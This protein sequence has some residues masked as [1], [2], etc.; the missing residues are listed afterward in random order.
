MTPPNVIQHLHHLRDLG[1]ATRGT[2]EKREQ[3]YLINWD[4]FRDICV[5]LF[6]DLDASVLRDAEILKHH[7][8]QKHKLGRGEEVKA[9]MKQSP[10]FVE[11]LKAYFIRRYEWYF[12]ARKGTRGELNEWLTY[13]F[14]TILE[15]IHEIENA[16]HRTFPKMNW[17][18]V[19]DQSLVDLKDLL[20]VWYTASQRAP[21]MWADS[22]RMALN[23]LGLASEKVSGEFYFY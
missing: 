20:Q 8:E 11:F 21:P 3:P 7:E 19:K 10:A 22:L 13:T 17:K 23:D 9:W 1:I 12:E 4:R 5:D 6:P 16:L 15:G 14:P 18:Q 2:K